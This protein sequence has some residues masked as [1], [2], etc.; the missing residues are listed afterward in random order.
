MKRLI[1]V[2][3]LGL[4]TTAQASPPPVP[5]GM[6]LPEGFGQKDRFESIDEACLELTNELAPKKYRRAVGDWCDRRS[7]ASTR[8]TVIVS[9]IDGSQIHDR[10]RPFAWRFYN[11]YFRLGILDPKNCKHHKIDRTIRH[12]RKSRQLAAKWPFNSGKTEDGKLKSSIA[13]Q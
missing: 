1:G 11:N 8:G 3:F 6:D 4:A 12:P 5:T 10:D 9:R 2:L 7:Y 13:T